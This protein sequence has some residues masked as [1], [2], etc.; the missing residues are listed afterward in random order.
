M[1]QPKG[2]VQ[3][4]VIH[5]VLMFSRKGALSLGLPGTNRVIDQ[6][7]SER[8]FSFVVHA[9]CLVFLPC[10]YSGMISSTLAYLEARE[11]HQPQVIL[12]EAVNIS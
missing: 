5:P 7:L 2:K 10:Y 3:S 1:Y 4:A 9:S 11:R 12:L 8:L 6:L